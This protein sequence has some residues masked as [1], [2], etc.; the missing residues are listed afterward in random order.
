[1]LAMRSVHPMLSVVLLA[2]L[3][4]GGDQRDDG[5]PTAP[6]AQ[7]PPPTPTRLTVAGR[8]V[9]DNR[10]TSELWVHG[11]YG[12]TATWGSRVSSGAS[13]AGNTI[14]VW[15][16]RAAVPVLLDSVRVANATTV[17]DVQVSSDGRYLV[18][19]TEQSPGS[20]VVYDLADPVRPRL[21]S[22]FTSPKITRGV[23][24]CEIQTINGRLTAFLSVNPG[25]NHPARLMI[26]DLGDPAAPTEVFTLDITSSF[27]HDVFVRDGLLF[28]AQWNNGLVI[29]DIGGGGRSGTLAAPVELGR[30]RT[31]GGKVHNIWWFH[32]PSSGR[33]TYAFV[34][35][36][37]PASLFT[38]SSGDIHV[39][40]ISSPA[41][42]REVAFYTVPG[43]GTHNFALDEANGFLY[44]AYYNGGVQVLDVRGDLATCTA[45]QK[46]ADGRCNLGLM[47]RTKSIG[48]LDQ[49]IPVFVWGVHLANRSLFASDMINGFWRLAPATR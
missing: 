48:L 38:A 40:D 34:G 15:D 5:S 29:H 12:Y 49:G 20:I 16:V 9:V 46:A 3:A 24:T 37:G 47:G 41:A 18:A 21:V 19:P 43:A 22:T 32:D 39:V 25:T 17:G 36:E 42:P 13:A 23:H 2:A 10:Y 4:C 1:M 26:V 11:N 27:V 14:H 28:S 7:N 8:G 45:A 44:A 30:L 6:P 33:K 31:N 35:E